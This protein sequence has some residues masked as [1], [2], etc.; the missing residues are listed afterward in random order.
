MSKSRDKIMGRLRASHPQVGTTEAAL[1]RLS[2]VPMENL[3]P[4]Q[5]VDRFVEQARLLSCN[6]YMSASASDAIRR[7]MDLLGDDKRVMSWAFEHIPLPGL[8]EA[9]EVNNIRV[10][11][12]RDETIRVGI[13]GADAALASTGSLVLLT[14]KGKYRLASLL[15]NVHIAII[16]K[17]QILADLETWVATVRQQGLD[18]FQNTASAMIISGPSSTADIA[19]QL[20]LGMHGPGELHIIILGPTH[21]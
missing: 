12:G 8:E 1:E 4:Q 7:V 6:V 9:F 2:L 14:G 3:L 11:S 15:P 16:R 20:I 10:I 18:V 21:S 17:D 5:T 19:M 13:T